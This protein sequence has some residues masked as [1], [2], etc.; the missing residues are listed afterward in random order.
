M[1]IYLLHNTVNGKGYVGQTTGTLTKRLYGH[2]W[3]S[4]KKRGRIIH[5]AI[6]KYGFDS[7]K[8]SVLKTCASQEELDAEEIRFISELGTLAPKG[9]NL[10]LGGNGGGKHS[11]VTKLKMSLQRKGKPLHVNTAKAL[12]IAR[13]NRILTEET[14]KRL[15][16]AQKGNK[17]RLN[18]HKTTE[19]RLK[20][21]V[22]QRGDKNHAAKLTW[23]IV[24][25]IRKD[26]SDGVTVVEL[27]NSYNITHGKISGI[28]H[29]RSWVPEGMAPFKE[30]LRKKRDDLVPLT[31]GTVK[32]IREDH[33]KGIS[34][35]DLS[36]KY[37]ASKTNVGRIV[38]Y[39]TWVPEG[40]DVVAPKRKSKIYTRLNWDIV[41]AIRLDYKNG[42]KNKALSIKHSVNL[43]DIGKII[44]AKIWVPES[45]VI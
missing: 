8:V 20:I 45:K 28:V 27:S 37:N 16:E 24:N 34:L 7:F 44:H 32:A 5:R 1:L 36:R 31:W 26:Y 29:Y 23:N 18:D 12:D 14:H 6:A 15:S 30:L 19:E 38:Y 41:N 13:R 21:S 22:A 43:T 4:T 3:D 2:K 42:L 10:A 40:V 25:S 33:A 39:K 17:K 11:E 9:Y 35:I